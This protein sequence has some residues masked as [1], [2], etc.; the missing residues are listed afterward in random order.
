MLKK[1]LLFITYAAIIL[2]ACLA[3]A[4][5]INGEMMFDRVDTNANGFI[6]KDEY[7]ANSEKRF[8]QMDTNKD[9]RLTEEEFD[10][11]REELKEKIKYKPNN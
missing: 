8:G 5:E 6:S 3:N 1:S 7:M 9:G 4:N 2:S 11:Y 10:S